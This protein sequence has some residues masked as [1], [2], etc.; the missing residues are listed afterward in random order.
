MTMDAPHL[1]DFTQ[2][3]SEKDLV[4]RP[5]VLL[6]AGRRAQKLT[7]LLQ[8]WVIPQILSGGFLKLGVPQKVGWFRREHP[9]LKWMMTGGTPI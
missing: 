9:K 6:P 7:K 2:R 4:H 5:D 1:A 3:S 8:L